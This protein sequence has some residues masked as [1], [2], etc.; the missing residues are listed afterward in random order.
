MR[1]FCHSPTASSPVTQT[2]WVR[3]G[4]G[5]VKQIWHRAQGTIHLSPYS[6]PCPNYFFFGTRAFRD[7][8]PTDRQF[9]PTAHALSAH[10]ITLTPSTAGSVI[11]KKF[12]RFFFDLRISLYKSVLHIELQQIFG[13]HFYHNLIL[14]FVGGKGY[15]CGL[16]GFVPFRFSA[17]LFFLLLPIWLNIPDCKRL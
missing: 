16:S 13:V 8:G 1:F 7:S 11:E 17:E 9:L 3:C 6:H 14:L 5:G 10:T 12:S 2:V 15:L 4:I